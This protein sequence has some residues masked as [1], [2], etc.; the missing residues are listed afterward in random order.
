MPDT[1]RI[2]VGV[3][4]ET[5]TCCA[6]GCGITFAVPVRWSR[7]R[8]LDHVD[9][10][11]PNGHTQYFPGKSDVEELQEQLATANGNLN[12][13]RGLANERREDINKLEKQ[14]TSLKGQV[15]K[16]KKRAVAGVCAFCHRRFGDYAAHMATE[17]PSERTD[18]ED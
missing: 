10:Y 9:W 15:T 13:Y 6:A 4:L 8:R 18:A 11:C 17:H 1:Y 16:L 5:L 3:E 7:Q 14:R 12:Y 2:D